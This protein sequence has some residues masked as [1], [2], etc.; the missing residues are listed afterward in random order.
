[1]LEFEPRETFDYVV[2]SGIFGLDAE[3]ARERILPTLERMVGWARIGA[4]VNFLSAAL[5][6]ARPRSASTWI[7]ARRSRR[8]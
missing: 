8:R 2:A 3:G 6:D 5:P 1:M 7:P 4:A